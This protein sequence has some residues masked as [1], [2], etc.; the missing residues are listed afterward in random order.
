MDYS[1]VFIAY[2]VRTKWK[3]VK[4]FLVLFSLCS[5]ETFI[6]VV[7]K[8]LIFWSIKHYYAYSVLR[9]FTY[10][11][12]YNSNKGEQMLRLFTPS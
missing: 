11:R 2:Q 7:D 5:Y 1:S 10:K 6:L 8:V 12:H 3:N 4:L 9:G